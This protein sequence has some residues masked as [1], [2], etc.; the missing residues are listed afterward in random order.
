MFDG[1]LVGNTALLFIHDDKQTAGFATT[2][3]SE[4]ATVTANYVAG[5]IPGGSYTVNKNPSGGT[6]QVTVSAGG[7][8]TADAAGV[9]VF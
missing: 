9:L 1:A 5:L 6:V 2:V 7:S 3:Y 4:P 8:S